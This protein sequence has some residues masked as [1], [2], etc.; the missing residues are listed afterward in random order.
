M[1]S[2]EKTDLSQIREILSHDIPTNKRT[3]SMGERNT[4]K[5]QN[6]FK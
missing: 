2:S 5:M 1:S 3:R 6:I 4:N